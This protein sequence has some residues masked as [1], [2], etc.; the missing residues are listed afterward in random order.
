MISR[1]LRF[2]NRETRARSD[3]L[4]PIR[5][6]WE[7]WAQ[8]LPLILNPGPEVT[9][10]E[11]LFTFQGKCPFRQYIPS[12]PG[13][14]G[15]KIWAAYAWNL[16]IYAGKAV[17]G[18]PE[19]KQGKRVFLDM[20]TG[21]QGHNITCDNFFKKDTFL[22]FLDVNIYGSKLTLNTIDVTL[23]IEVKMKKEIKQIYLRYVFYTPQ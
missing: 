11:R 20:I 3:K 10:D 16:Q 14:Y 8:F 2:D 5:D 17:S 6:V 15:I 9:V 19:K 1:V 22:P 21:L 13:K 23:V 12:K 7:R 4:A 18:I